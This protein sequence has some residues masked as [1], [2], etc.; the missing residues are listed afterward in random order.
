M[1]AETSLICAKGS[2]GSCWTLGARTRR[3]GRCCPLRRSML[4]SIT[5]LPRRNGTE[6]VLTCTVMRMRCPSPI[7]PLT[8]SFCWMSWSTC[9]AQRRRCRRFAAYS[10]RTAACQSKCH[11][12]IPFTMPL[13]ISS[14]GLCSDCGVWLKNAA[15]QLP[16]NMSTAARLNVRH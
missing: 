12:F 13:W 1:S 8:M 10:S 15:F 9:P 14:A 3:R 5:M 11:S 4:A 6:H 2:G 16:R 7:A